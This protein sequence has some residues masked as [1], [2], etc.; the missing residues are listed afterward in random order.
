MDM[1]PL[2]FKNFI[3]ADTQKWT[4]VVKASGATVD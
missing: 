3:A 2:A 4:R 1:T